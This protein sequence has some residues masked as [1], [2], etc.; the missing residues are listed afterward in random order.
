MN[1]IT[2]LAVCALISGCLD[3][4]TERTNPLDSGAPLEAA[5]T[6][7]PDTIS[8][9]LAS[10]TPRLVT[11]PALPDAAE[12][13]FSGPGFVFDGSGMIRPVQAS[14]SP[15]Q[16]TLSATIGPSRNPRVV[17]KIVTVRQRPRDLAFTCVPACAW[18]DLGSDATVRVTSRDSLGSVVRGLIWGAVGDSFLIRDTTI[19]SSQG[20]AD[21]ARLVP[22]KNGSTWLVASKSLVP[23]LTDSIP[24]VV[25]Q[26]P[27]G[28]QV[29]CPIS[30]IVGETR[31]INVIRFID[32][33]GITYQKADP[34]I[35]WLPGG[36]S[37][38]LDPGVVD[39]TVTAGGLITANNVGVWQSNALFTETNQLAAQCQIFVN[40]PP[41]P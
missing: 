20:S 33:A 7:V 24:L 35:R 18:S 12:V 26:V 6:G 31:Q 29:E 32:S 15:E 17:T 41:D 14:F 39:V 1:R 10:Y 4:P 23:P 27:T 19:V 37:N 22:M 11:S 13:T 2:L 21:G 34:A 3:A 36:P 28:A 40:S 9:L 38:P 30:M 5:I 8:S 16:W 25:S